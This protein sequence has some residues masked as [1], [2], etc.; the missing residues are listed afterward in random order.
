MSALKIIC[1]LRLRKNFLKIYHKYNEGFLS[2]EHAEFMNDQIGY[3]I[4]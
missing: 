3:Y 1:L 2:I 4:L